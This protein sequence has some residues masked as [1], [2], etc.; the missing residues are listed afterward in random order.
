VQV[1][2][3]ILNRSPSVQKPKLLV[4]ELWG[5]GDLVIGSPFLQAATQKFAVTLLAKPYAE[6][7]RE[8]FW[9][10]VKVV[11]FLAPW[12]AFRHKYRLFSWPWSEI[13]RLRPLAAEG[14]SAGLSA[15]SD[16]RD[17][18]VL[19]LLRVKTRLGFSRL[20]SRL[21]LTKALARPEREAHRYEYWRVLGQALGLE[22]PPR[23]NIPTA[24]TRR[25]TEV[26]VHTGAGQP[27]RVWPLDRYRRL[28]GRLRQE[29]HRVQVAC[30][31]EQRGWWRAVGEDEV[32]TPRTVVEL[33][34]LIDRA[35]AFIGNDSGPGH[36]AAACGVRTL[37]IFGPQLPQW[38]APLHPA[39]Q[40]VEGKPCP[41]KPCSDYCRFMSPHCLWNLSEEEVWARVEQFIALPALQPQAGEPA[42]RPPYLSQLPSR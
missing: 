27:I 32:G 24:A 26:L 8:R 23:A 38:F 39:A 9:P 37:T 5:L 4:V 1:P 28:I 31:P 13:G 25:S 36:L 19:R 34:A 30:D 7:L 12:T 18:I 15:R 11:P 20:G 10:E 41:Y 22:L 35:G 2:V 3:P 29:G 6:D 40:W 14:F 17:H 21:L 42:P 33:M 16:P